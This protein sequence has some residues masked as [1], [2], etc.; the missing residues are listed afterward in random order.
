MPQ[1]ITSNDSGESSMPPSTIYLDDVAMSYTQLPQAEISGPL[2]LGHLSPKSVGAVLA[3]NLDLDA[4][5]IR[6]I[7][8]SLIKTLCSCQD[9]WNDEKQALEARNRSLEDR[10]LLHEE[11]LVMP[12]EGYIING[13]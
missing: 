11:T 3:T 7:I 9:R 4:I 13:N 12:P 5:V 1:S 8:D 10:V 2:S 6:Q